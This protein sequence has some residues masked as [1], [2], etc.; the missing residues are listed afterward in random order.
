MVRVFYNTEFEIEKSVDIKTLTQISRSKLLWIDLQFASDEERQTVESF[1]NINFNEQQEISDIESNS[2]FYEAD[3]FIYIQSN[4]IAKKETKFFNT[5]VTFFLI[6]NILITYRDADLP[7]FA[8][9]VKK[10]KRNRNVFKNGSDVLEGILETK[11]DIDSDFIEAIAKEISI[12]SNGLSLSTT[13]EEELLLKVN[14][15]QE[16]AMLLRESFTDKQRVVSSLL[17]C[18]IFQH[19][20]RVKIVIKDINAMLDY[21]SFIFARLEYLQN[22]LLGMINMQQNKTIKIFTIVSVVFMPP[23]LIAS[24]YGMN[25]TFMP[26]L[27][28]KFGYPFALLL[29]VTSSLLTL[30]IFKRK[31][32]L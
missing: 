14:S 32:W 12:L 2:R 7:S 20:S 10:I 21:S 28:W 16:N 26:E 13:N 30:F 25:F 3:N 22:T 31:R 4:F 5:P 15:Y 23:T 29:I 1:F 27:T 9:L 8:E 19:D 24:I 17:K 11:V 6:D 18:N